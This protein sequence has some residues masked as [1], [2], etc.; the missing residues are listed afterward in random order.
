MQTSNLIIFEIRKGFILNDVTALHIK[1]QKDFVDVYGNVRKAG[2]EWLIDKSIKDVHILDAYET[3]VQ[4]KRIIVLTQN[5]YCY[6]NNPFGENGRPRY[7]EQIIKRGEAK[8]FLRPGEELHEGIKNIYVI[9]EEEAL[10]LKAKVTYF[11]KKTGKEYKPGQR[12]MI[13]G[14]IDFI[15]DSAV[16]VIEKR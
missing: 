12:W 9:H 13:R 11:D 15:P 2:E 8:F 16:E 1:A 6:I 14:P 7:G 4:E 5:Q 10:L 3:L